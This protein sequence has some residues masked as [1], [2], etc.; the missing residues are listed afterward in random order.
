MK[1]II[2]PLILSIQGCAYTAA[3]TATWAVTGKST[4][5]HTLSI[6]TQNDCNTYKLATGEQ[7]YLCERARDPA[8]VYNRNS[9]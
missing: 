2:I 4:G 7:D 8:D 1:W 9:Y 5:D 3:S 6:A